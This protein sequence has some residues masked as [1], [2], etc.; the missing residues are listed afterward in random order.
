[1]RIGRNP[2]RKIERTQRHTEVTLATIVYIPFLSGYYAQSLDVLRLCLGSLRAHTDEPHELLVFDNGSCPEVR[3]FLADALQEG[4]ID[5]LLLSNENLGK[6]GAWNI[7]FEAAPGDVMAFCDSDIFFKPGWLTEHLRILKTFPDVGMIT[8]LPIRQQV[9]VFTKTGLAKARTDPR[10]SVENGDF[11][12]DE[13]MAA[14]CVGVN[15]DYE[16]YRAEIAGTHDIRLQL[17]DVRALLGACHFQF[18]AYKSVLKSL[19]PLSAR[20]LLDG[21]A[22]AHGSESEL[23]QRVEERALLRLST[24]TPYVH[25]LGNTLSPEWKQWLE[26]LDSTLA[27]RNDA[28]S[29]A[30]VRGVSEW[31][32]RLSQNRYVRAV[33]MRLYN[34]LFRLHA[35]SSIAGTKK[36]S[37]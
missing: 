5:Y 8:G 13:A 2:T 3:A 1:M 25:H 17:G 30:G 18:V 19:L 22:V 11:I 16:Q 6:A 24:E 28:K 21:S 31:E 15:R 36:L 27:I 12:S 34:Y 32:S 29:R 4:A 23:D 20:L 35:A 14:Y 33:S 26:R 10:I 9:D 7:V 37:Q